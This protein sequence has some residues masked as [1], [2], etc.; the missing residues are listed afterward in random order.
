MS[1]NF[2]VENFTDED[3]DEGVVVRVTVGDVYVSV[4][5]DEHGDVHV[6][7]FDGDEREH[8]VLGE[9]AE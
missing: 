4:S 2:K 5:Q 8:V 9:D 7:A 1:K 6:V 3:T